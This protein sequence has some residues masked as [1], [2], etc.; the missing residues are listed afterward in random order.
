MYFS[1]GNV[2]VAHT[3][4]LYSYK[5][6]LPLQ[7]GKEFAIYMLPDQMIRRLM[8]ISDRTRKL[9]V[10]FHTDYVGTW[11][12]RD[13]G[14]EVMET[15]SVET[16]IIGH[17]WMLGGFLPV[18]VGGFM[19]ALTHAA[20]A[21]IIRRAWTKNPDKGI[22]FFAVLLYVFIW[23]MNWDFI[24]MFRSFLWGLIYAFVGYAIISPFLR[25]GRTSIDTTYEQMEGSE[26]IL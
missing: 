16:S 19:V 4:S 15:T 3:P 22:F 8:G 20:V 23:C 7:Y 18:L 25:H 14:L 26:N 5:P 12:L 17:F 9:S 1:A 11:L 2:I 24:E 10:V 21:G 13:Y 6:F